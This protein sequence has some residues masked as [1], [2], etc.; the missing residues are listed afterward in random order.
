MDWNTKTGLMPLQRR[1]Q[2]HPLGLSAQSRYKNSEIMLVSPQTQQN[3][4]R[5]R[6][7]RMMYVSKQHYDQPHQGP[8]IDLHV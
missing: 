6:E 1:E 7:S 8:H 3:G 5:V 2:S 4:L